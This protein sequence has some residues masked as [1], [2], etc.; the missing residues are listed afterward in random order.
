MARPAFLAGVAVAG[1]NGLESL[2]AKRMP[3]CLALVFCCLPRERLPALRV[4]SRADAQIVNNGRG[5]VA[6]AVPIRHARGLEAWRLGAGVNCYRFNSSIRPLTLRKRQKT[7]TNQRYTESQRVKQVRRPRQAPQ[8]A[9]ST[10]PG[11][12][13]LA[14]AAGAFAR[15]GSWLRRALTGGWPESARSSSNAPSRPVRSR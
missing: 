13:R 3:S 12:A 11:P 15:R 14:P 4:A 9:P 10:R 6:L 8:T 1:S 5:R 7:C 2:K